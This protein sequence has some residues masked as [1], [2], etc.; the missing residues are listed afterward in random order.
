MDG[1][2]PSDL[3]GD[4]D[5]ALF[6]CC[7]RCERPNFVGTEPRCGQCGRPPASATDRVRCALAGA[8]VRSVSLRALSAALREADIVE[9]ELGAVKLG[10][11]LRQLSAALHEAALETDAALLRLVGNL[12]AA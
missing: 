2:K 1:W 7:L 4:P 10:P 9:D 8:L 11:E 12:A 6:W 3:E 5:A